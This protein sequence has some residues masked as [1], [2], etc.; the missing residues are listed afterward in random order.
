MFD[1]YESDDYEY[2]TFE[3]GD[4]VQIYNSKEGIETWLEA[5]ISNVFTKAYDVGFIR[6]GRKTLI[7][8][9]FIFKLDGTSSD[10]FKVGEDVKFLNKD[11]NIYIKAKVLEVHDALLYNVKIID[12]CEYQNKTFNR[13]PGKVRRHKNAN[14]LE[15]FDKGEEVEM[16]MNRDIGEKELWIKATVSGIVGAEYQ[17]KWDQ[18]LLDKKQRYYG[19][20]YGNLRYPFALRKV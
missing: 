20:I 17:M 13:P 11:E 14:T 3:Q 15:T 18:N 2:G 10:D 5:H 4:F 1:S 19:R 6:N 16:L 9:D 8:P 7:Y 12:Y